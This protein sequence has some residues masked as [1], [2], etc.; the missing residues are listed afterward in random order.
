MSTRVA[1]DRLVRWIEVSGLSNGQL[2]AQVRDLAQRSGYPQVHPDGRRVR[3]W[4][5]GERPRDPVPELLMAVLSRC[6]GH[7]L[8]LDDL[9]LGDDR[10]RPLSE[11]P[12][13]THVLARE[14]AAVTR[15]D[16]VRPPT[17]DRCPPPLHG[18]DLLETV[19]PWAGVYAAPAQRH[20]PHRLDHADVDRL[21]TLIQALRTL[22]NLHGGGMARQ[23]VLGQLTG[24]TD[25]IAAATYTDGVGQRLFTALGDLAG[26][27]GWMSHDVG[28]HQPAQTY[29]LLALRAAKEARNP[30][31]GAHILNC[32]ARQATHLNRPDDA[33]ELVHLA[34]HGVRRAATPTVRAIL[35][36]L[37]ARAHAMKGNSVEFARAAHQAETAFASGGESADE[38]VWARFFDTSEFHATIG[39]GHQ[40]LARQTDP[41]HTLPAVGMI[42]DAI[43]ARPPER[44]RSLAFDH[45]GLSRALLV[46]EETEEALF[47]IRAAL[48]LLADLTSTRVLDRLSEV[49]DEARRAASRGDVHAQNLIEVAH[50]HTK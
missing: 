34:L 36:S 46:A 23:A 21:Q 10:L 15:S 8:T 31:L 4:R 14:L 29:F 48:D 16:I 20:G 22:D 9:G 18:E 37:E 42:R 26:I 28:L 45:I 17:P 43:A 6:T 44:H 32:M 49:T 40:I 39:V 47:H 24:V 7:T 11:R 41:A 5:Q 19:R 50:H 12:W 33:L 3:A 13:T 25:L 35:H 30:H 1:N 38:P 27:A 2:A